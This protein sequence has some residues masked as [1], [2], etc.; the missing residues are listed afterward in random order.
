MTKELSP[1]SITSLTSICYL[2]CKFSFSIL[3]LLSKLCSANILTVQKAFLHSKVR[4]HI[5]DLRRFYFCYL[6]IC[7]MQADTVLT[8]AMEQLELLKAEVILS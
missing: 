7:P 5:S 4:P 2:L 6:L 1:T 3:S 8:Y